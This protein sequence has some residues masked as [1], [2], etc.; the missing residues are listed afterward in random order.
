MANITL[1]WVTLGTP[2]QGEGEGYD[3]TLTWAAAGTPKA[4]EEVTLSWA[5]LATPGTVGGSLVDTHAAWLKGKAD[6]ITT[7][8]AFLRGGIELTSIAHAWLE[9][10]E[11][12]A[13]YTTHPAWMYGAV[14]VVT[15]HAAWLKGYSTPT[16]VCI[17]LIS[18]NGSF[19]KYF[20]VLQE[21]YDDGSW[22]RNESL[23]RTVEGKHDRSIGS[24]Y[25]T[26]ST[27]ILVRHTETETSY[28]DIED[29]RTFYKYN[30]VAGSPSTKITFIDHRGDT[31]YVNLVGTMKGAFL[32]L[33]VEGT[34]SWL[35]YKLTFVEVP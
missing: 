4:T 34:T 15:T 7:H 26:W 6:G 25:R 3:I 19:W 27:I 29:L 24:T 33:Q 10:Y 23:R 14:G 8:S 28:G 12:E 13:A 32:G 22:N 9:G 1:G 35:I 17:T 11:G 30:D 21:G 2:E 5:T 18:S 20:R 31:A 16:G